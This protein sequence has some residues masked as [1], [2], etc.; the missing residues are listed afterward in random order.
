MTKYLHIIFRHLHPC[1]FSDRGTIVAGDEFRSFAKISCININSNLC[2]AVYDDTN[3]SVAVN[4]KCFID[5]GK[6]SLYSVFSSKSSPTL[7]RNKNSC[8]LFR[9]IEYSVCESCKYSNIMIGIYAPS[10]KNKTER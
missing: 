7:Q 8:N 9:L 5:S 4:Q 1:E 10:I 3:Q 6:F 2:Q